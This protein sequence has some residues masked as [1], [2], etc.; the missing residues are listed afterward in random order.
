MS[1][2]VKFT[3]VF[4]D[5]INALSCLGKNVNEKEYIV[6]ILWTL[7]LKFEAKATSIKESSTFA[8]MNVKNLIG[9]LET[10]EVKA[11]ARENEKEE[12]YKKKKDVAF[13]SSFPSSSEDED[14]EANF[15]RRRQKGGSSKKPR[16]F[17]CNEMGHFKNDCPL[18][19]KKKKKFAKT[20]NDK[21]HALK[22]HGT[23]PPHPVKMK[24]IAI[25]QYNLHG[26]R[27][28]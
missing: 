6:K 17:E 12:E 14:K 2:F 19:K 23:I 15:S 27:R 3:L 4:L 11:D 9:S 24:M 13:R 7:T 1:L 10:Y 20:S 5:I 26:K 28:R 22:P 25:W 8:D 18:L 21:E 16:C